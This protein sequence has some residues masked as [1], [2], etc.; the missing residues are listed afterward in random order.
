M[1]TIMMYASAC[2]L[3][4]IS[5]S[6]FECKSI[7]TG[8]SFMPLL[9]SPVVGDDAGIASTGSFS[10]PR[11]LSM[12]EQI[13]KYLSTIKSNDLFIDNLV[14]KQSSVTQKYK[15][16]LFLKK[17]FESTIERIN[18]E[19]VQPSNDKSTLTLEDF[20]QAELKVQDILQVI[21]KRLAMVKS[22]IPPT[23]PF[24]GFF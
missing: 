9:F 6:Y 5:L 22:Y 11:V 12:I 8:D 17:C 14:A 7:G 13:I 10:N 4:L 1:N 20:Q 23:M 16:L 21:Q 15:L 24:L 2:I 18:Q 19:L 3:V